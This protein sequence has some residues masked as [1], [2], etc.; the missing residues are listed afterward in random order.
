M[1]LAWERR[2]KCTIF[3]WDS[4]KERDHLDDQSVDGGGDQNGSWED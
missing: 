3:W 1:W 2:G 4:Q